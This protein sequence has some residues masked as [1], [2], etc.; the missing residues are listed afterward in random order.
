M[1]GISRKPPCLHPIL[2]VAYSRAELM[3]LPKYQSSSHPLGKAPSPISSQH[4]SL[5]SQTLMTTFRKGEWAYHPTSE[6]SKLLELDIEG[7]P[8]PFR[9]R[10]F[11][12]LF[13]S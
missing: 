11:F 2:V 10:S 12:S 1:E 3:R 6:A 9:L 8:R 5:T 4:V 13:L 7:S